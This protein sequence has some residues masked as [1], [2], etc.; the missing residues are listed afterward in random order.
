MIRRLRLAWPHQFVPE[1]PERDGK[2]AFRLLAASDEVA[3]SIEFEQNREAIGPID[4]VLG[5]GDLEPEYLSFLAEAFRVPMLYVRGN[6]DRGAN[7]TAHAGQLPAPLDARTDQIAGLPVAGLS[8]PGS[9]RGSAIRDETD[10]WQQALSLY[11]RAVFG[12]RP[13]I[14]ISHVPPRGLGDTPED[15]YHRGFAA[16]HWLCRRLRPRLWLHGHT[17]RAAIRD[18]CVEWGST[19]LVNV[20]GAVLIELADGSASG[21]TIESG[22]ETG[23]PAR[24]RSGPAGSS[25]KEM[26]EP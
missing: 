4:G 20:T 18:W 9:E 25:R 17:S 13:L 21:A 11:L 22:N 23:D 16:Y 2:R 3:P 10:A 26:E 19:T 12:R 24:S 5:C 8:W 6:H 7:W 15:A 14:V 1:A